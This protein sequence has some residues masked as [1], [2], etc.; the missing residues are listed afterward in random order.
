[1]PDVLIRGVD[2]DALKRL[3]ASAKKKGRSFQSEAKQ[4]LE[5]ASGN[6]NL[7]AILDKWQARVAGRK[8]AKS[9]DLINEGRER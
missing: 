3:K 5:Q 2:A 4:I 8:L 1:M 7:Q 6:A 9:V